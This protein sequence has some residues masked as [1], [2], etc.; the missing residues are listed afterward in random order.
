M[1]GISKIIYA[2]IMCACVFACEEETLTITDN[3]NIYSK[4]QVS[5]EIVAGD[6]ILLKLEISAS[7]E[8]VDSVCEWGIYI[9]T[10]S[11]LINNANYYPAASDGKVIVELQL[12]LAEFEKKSE[13]GTLT[14]K[15]DI[16]IGIYKKYANTVTSI[17]TNNPENMV[18][19]HD[20]TFTTGDATD[21][22]ELEAFLTCN[23]EGIS[24]YTTFGVKIEGCSELTG[25]YCS[26]NTIQEYRLQNLQPGATYSYRAYIYVD[27]EYYYGETRSFT[28]KN[29]AE[30][31]AC[32]MVDLGLSVKW[33]SCN[34][35]A[36]SPEQYGSYYSWGEITTKS[37]YTWNT[38]KWCDGTMT[39]LTKY[40]ADAH[41][42]V[43]DNK[44]SLDPDDDVAHIRWGGTWRIP[45]ID[46]MKELISKCTWEWTTQRGVNGQKVTGPNGNSIFLPA[47]GYRHGVFT[48]NNGTYGCYW[49][50]SLGDFYSSSAGYLSFDREKILSGG[51]YRHRGRPI[52]PVSE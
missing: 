21:I 10:E 46:E 19:S 5:L 2:L 25:E 11:T 29:S 12:P 9:P 4:E 44:K 20:I 14:L 41:I 28:T 49:S 39:S 26:F 3:S 40:N 24:Q 45:S 37:N 31:V 1:K 13:T 33:A 47:A 43:V 36:S 22:K 15:R 27:G 8:D 32:E 30:D 16:E 18:L 35:G 17:V 34:V 48:E 52:R 42:G 7:I 6:S 50:S 51:T 38:Y 23:Y